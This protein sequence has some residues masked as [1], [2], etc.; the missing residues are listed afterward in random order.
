MV[1]FKLIGAAAV[2]AVAIGLSAESI[3]PAEAAIITGSISG[4]VS[5]T[6]GSV[7]GV[8]LGDPVTGFYSYDDAA[9]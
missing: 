4:S 9:R 2:G 1:N 5:T 6:G 3:T 7:P 8:F